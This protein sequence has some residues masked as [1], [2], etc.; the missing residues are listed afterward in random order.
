MEKTYDMFGIETDASIERECQERKRKAHEERCK[1]IDCDILMQLQNYKM[2]D[3]MAYRKTKASKKQFVVDYLMREIPRIRKGPDSR[4]KQDFAY[5]PKY[6]D[7]PVDKAMCEKMAQY[8]LETYA[9]EDGVRF[10]RVPTG[11]DCWYT[12]DKN[13]NNVY[14]THHKNCDIEREYLEKLIREKFPFPNEK[15]YSKDGTQVWTHHAPQELEDK[16]SELARQ[17]SRYVKIVEVD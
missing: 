17:D 3:E 12:L 10:Y 2:L 1:I 9:H 8:I 11:D 6:K 15:Y 14:A 4:G 16:A 5:S 13:G 7:K